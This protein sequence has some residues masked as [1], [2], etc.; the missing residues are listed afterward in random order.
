[1]PS[2]QNRLKL[3]DGLNILDF[4]TLLPGPYATMLMADMG[5]SVTRV[6]HPNK[7]DLTETLPPYIGGT[8][9]LSAQ[10]NHNK[11]TLALDLKQA[12]AIEHVLN[13]ID[14]Y[15]IVLEQFRPGVMTKLGLDYPSLKA[16]KPDLIYC[17]ITGYGQTGPYAYKA[18]HDINYLAL[19]GI[20]SY[21]GSRDE[22]PKLNG[23]QIA[24]MAGGSHHAVMS[25]LAAVIH[26]QRTGEGQYIDVSMTDCAF[27]MNIISGAPMLAG[28]HEP[29]AESE[30]LNG[31]FFYDYYPTL[32]GRYL[33]VGGLEPKFIARLANLLE[34]PE[35]GKFALSPNPT[36]QQEL[37][38][39]LQT[40]FRQK[41]LDEWQQLFAH[42]DVC[43]EPVLTV[44]E[45]SEHPH[46]IARGSLKTTKIGDQ[47]IKQL[48]YPVKHYR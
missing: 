37:K 35:L 2:P 9:A 11:T 31:G 16:L 18:G 22:G 32:D 6:I 24:D 46:F 27:S 13:Q 39:Q 26:K 36:K 34:C 28:G 47:E 33:S 40:I 45:A 19:S 1:M 21:S 30:L 38:Q 44:K 3:L 5:A 25:I 15:D 29:K 20:A 42:E 12:E 4:S 17:S 14:Q 8:S 23:I 10:L 41:T 7:P 43:V 48:A